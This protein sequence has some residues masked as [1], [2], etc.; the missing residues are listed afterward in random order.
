MFKKMIRPVSFSLIFPFLLLSLSVQTAKAQLVD[1]STVI[2]GQRAEVNR[3]RVA[4]FMGRED[5]QQVMLRNGVDPAEAQKR[6][7][8]LS[9][10]ELV[11]IANSMDQLPAGGD[12][13]GAIVGAAVFVFIVLLITDLIGLTHVFPFVNHPHR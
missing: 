12:A 5:V 1:T 13:V 3:A 8:S 11:K 9:D 4:A 6:V 7:E 2:A 10:A